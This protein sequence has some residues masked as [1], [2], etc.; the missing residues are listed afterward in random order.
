MDSTETITEFFSP[1]KLIEECQK[2]FDGLKE[3]VGTN[4]RTKKTNS[5]N[6]VNYLGLP[7]ET[8]GKTAESLR[9]IVENTDNGFAVSFVGRSH[10]NSIDDGTSA[11]DAQEQFGSFEAFYS[12]I[13][14]WARA[15]EDRYGLEFKSINDYL[16]AKKIWEEGTIL[17]RAGGGTE[18]MRDLLEPALDKISETTSQ[19]LE[20]GVFT[21][22]DSIEI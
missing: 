17:Y 6:D 12:A 5:G 14:K 19:E 21:L 22:L 15:K 7:E 8:T 20:K 18:I 9:T 13:K 2:V 10:I 3:N 16:A 4:V 11:A 1:Q